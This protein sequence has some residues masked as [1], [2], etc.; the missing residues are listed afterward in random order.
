M[1]S[2]VEGGIMRRQS[3]FSMYRLYEQ[4]A[5]TRDRIRHGDYSFEAVT[6]RL[7]YPSHIGKP[8]YDLTAVAKG[9]CTVEDVLGQYIFRLHGLLD[10]VMGLKRW[11]YRWAAEEDAHSRIL[12]RWLGYTG[13]MSE[14]ERYEFHLDSN[15]KLWNPAAVNAAFENPLYALI[16]VMFQELATGYA[17]LRLSEFAKRCGQEALAQLC[18]KPLA[19]EEMG[20][21]RFYLAICKIL[22]LDMPNEFTPLVYQ[23]FD[24]FSMPGGYVEGEGLAD[25]AEWTVIAMREGVV[26][27]PRMVMQQ[28]TGRIRT[29]LSSERAEREKLKQRCLGEWQKAMRQPFEILGLD[30]PPSLKLAR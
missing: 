28:M 8:P 16:Y 29:I 14:E 6:T 26:P 15:R 9:Y 25:Y 17:Y 2:L 19:Q 10:P 23:A 11:L 4:E 7:P 21:H 13:M 1:S 12:G 22:Q 20:H 24:E 18:R 3:E 30:I 27:D 5:D